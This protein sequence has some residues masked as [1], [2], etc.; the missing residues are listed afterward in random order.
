MNMKTIHYTKDKN[1][2]EIQIRAS[3]IEDAFELANV[4]NERVKKKR[5][6]E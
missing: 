6:E 5:K 3:C 1:S 2:Y 4:L